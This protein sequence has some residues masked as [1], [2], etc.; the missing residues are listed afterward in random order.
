MELE[1][2]GEQEMENLRKKIRI[3]VVD[4]NLRE[5]KKMGIAQQKVFINKYGNMLSLLEV[6]KKDKQRMLNKLCDLREKYDSMKIMMEGKIKE[7]EERLEVV[8]WQRM[9]N[10]ENDIAVMAQLKEQLTEMQE[11]VISWKES[12]SQRR[13]NMSKKIKTL[14]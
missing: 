4:T 1:I 11:I 3:K 6:V 14:I 13:S 12:F 7:Y 8:Q 9:D 2:R 5:L 10:E